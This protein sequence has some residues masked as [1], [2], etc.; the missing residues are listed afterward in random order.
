MTAP[1]GMAKLDC[2]SNG[3]RRRFSKFFPQVI[4]LCELYVSPYLM[5]LYMKFRHIWRTEI[6][7]ILFNLM[8][9]I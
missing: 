9:A 5:N 3:F 6:R 8:K 7:D 2:G 4:S 1:Q